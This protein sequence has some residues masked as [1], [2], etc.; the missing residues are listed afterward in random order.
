MVSKQESADATNQNR[1]GENLSLYRYFFGKGNNSHMV[2]NLFKNRFW[3]TNHEKNEMAGVN[4]MWTQIKNINHMET[5]LC[6]Y[7]ERR[8][9]IN[10]KKGGAV[11]PTTMVKQPMST[12]NSKKKEK[13][14]SISGDK[15]T[16]TNERKNEGA[17]S[18]Q[19][20]ANIDIKLYNK[21][22]DNFHV[23]NKKALLLNMRNYYEAMGQNVFDNL[24][25]TFHIKNGL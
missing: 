15:G 1:A 17:P 22:E 9:G 24:P 18:A 25:V 7:P 2:K 12:P 5:L 16:I 11:A 14:Q 13:Q 19:V 21:I 8:S 23:A 20:T 4:F 10:N 6:K 3:W